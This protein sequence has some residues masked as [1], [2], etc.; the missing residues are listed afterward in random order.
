MKTSSIKSAGIMA[1]AGVA[2]LICLAGRVPDTG[3]VSL[4][5]HGFDSN[6]LFARI[7][8]TNG[9]RRTIGYVG[10]RLVP[11]YSWMER[12]PNGEWVQVGWTD[13]ASSPLQYR[14][15]AP[16]SRMIFWIRVRHQSRPSK[17]ELVYWIEKG[18][19]DAWRSAPKWLTQSLPWLSG[20][21]DRRTLGTP[22]VGPAGQT[23]T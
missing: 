21:G 16:F 2:L 11:E 13:L 1:F 19:D 10:T 12:A 15:L 5:M 23:S 9:T 22:I 18:R 17:I 4:V 8:L 14:R 7:E 6:K 3:E 20:K